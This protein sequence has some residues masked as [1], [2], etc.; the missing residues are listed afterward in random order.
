MMGGSL[1]D[2]AA[3][4]SDD[5]LTGNAAASRVVDSLTIRGCRCVSTQ[6][7][8]IIS[9]SR[10]TQSCVIGGGWLEGKKLYLEHPELQIP[11]YTTPSPPFFFFRFAR[12]FFLLAPIVS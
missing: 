3:G 10:L 1:S 2:G 7:T 5:S 12:T 8:A 4:D 11:T 6:R 9:R